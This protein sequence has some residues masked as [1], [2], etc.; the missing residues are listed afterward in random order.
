M[1]P[2]SGGPI[3]RDSIWFFASVRD[4]HI[5]TYAPIFF[6][7]NAGNPNAWTYEAD[8]S[9]KPAFND[10][11]FRG[12]DGRV[13]WQ[14]NATNKF[15]IAYDYQNQCN[16][17]RSLTAS[18]APEANV[19]NHA[20]LEPKDMWFLEWT[21]PL[22]SRLLAEMRGYRHREHAYRPRTNLYFTNDPGGKKLNGVVEQSTGLTYRGA[23]GD[24]RDTWMY[25]SIVT[26]DVSYITGSHA[27][28]VGFNLGFNFQDQSIFSTDSAMSFQF[29]NGTPNRLTLDSTP[30]RRKSNSRDHGAFVQDRWTVDRL[31]VTAGL[32]YDYFHVFFPPISVGPGEFLPNR[33]LSFPRG[34]GVRWHDLEPRTGVAYD[35]FGNGKTALKASLNRYLPFYGLQLNVGTDAGTFSTNM[36]PVARLVT[37]TNRSWSD[38]NSNFVPDCELT[39]PVANGECGAMSPS[40]FGSPASGVTYDP[41]VITGWNKREYNWQFSTG[42]QQQLMRQLSLDVGY[43]RTWYGNLTVTDNRAWTAADFDSFAITAPRDARL[44]DGGGYIVSGLYDVKTSRFSVPTDNYITYASHY[45]HQQRRW[46]GIDVTVNGRPRPGLMLQGGTSTGRTTLDNCE[47]V[48]DIPELLQRSG[49]PASSCRTQTKFLTDLKFLGTY[50]VPRI[51]VQVAATVQSVPGPEIAANYV[52]TKAVVTPALGRPLAGNV[53]N[54]TVNIVRPGTLY[55]DRANST[56]LRVSKILMFGNTRTTAGVDIYNLFNSSTVLT[57]NNAFATWQRPLSIPNARWA[58]LVLQFDF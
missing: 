21:A 37:S 13:T 4:L 24:N 9:R 1:N 35:L 55:G 22:T 27:L 53:A 51:D 49:L 8:T 58:K 18:I 11:R 52:V 40:N 39:N 31:T 41:D 6:N 23:V 32:R 20:M 50:L 16:C 5:G 48:D 34:E 2:T 15:A 57:L 28:K 25:T 14:A 46:D 43:Y 38:A 10:S 36:A 54:M 12:V 33:N 30:W 7:K 17:P 26:G 29:N 3:N 45:G 19:R 56:Q 47:I 44:P 42:I